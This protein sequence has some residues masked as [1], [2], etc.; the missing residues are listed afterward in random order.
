MPWVFVGTHAVS[1]WC[2]WRFKGVEGARTSEEGFCGRGF[3][4]NRLHL[5]V[6]DSRTGSP[7]RG[8]D[9]GGEGALLLML[10]C[11]CCC[12]ELLMVLPVWLRRASQDEV[13]QPRADAGEAG[14]PKRF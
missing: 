9:D 13:E 12:L 10:L 3:G 1:E 8:D 2:T 11:C 14:M 7:L 6:E 4:F 5:C